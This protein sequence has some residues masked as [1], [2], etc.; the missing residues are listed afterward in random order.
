MKLLV[1]TSAL[2]ALLLSDDRNHPS[3]AEF[4]RRHPRARYVLTELILSEV[5]T[6]IRARAGAERAA[7]AGDDLLRSQRFELLFVDAVVAAG[8]LRLM[9]RFG[10]K[11]LSFTDCASFEVMTRLKLE[12]AFSFDRDFRDCG[13]SMVP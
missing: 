9:R 12:A 6:R 2:L 10:D 3:A 8:A 4:V 5:V 13:F 7:S 1:D 11:R